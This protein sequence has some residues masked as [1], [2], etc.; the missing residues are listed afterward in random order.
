MCFAIFPVCVN[1][2]TSLGHD[3]SWTSHNSRLQWRMEWSL[4]CVWLSPSC[5]WCTGQNVHWSSQIYALLVH[6]FINH[7]S[8][9]HLFSG[10]KAAIQEKKQNMCFKTQTQQFAPCKETPT[11]IIPFSPPREA[12]SSLLQDSLQ[13]VSVLGLS[14]LPVLFLIFS[15]LN[16]FQEKVNLHL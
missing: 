14:F 3:L 13:Q 10:S 15:N 2:D 9:S 5:L 7:W 11:T 1:S 6:V 16:T 12:L 4:D 8:Y